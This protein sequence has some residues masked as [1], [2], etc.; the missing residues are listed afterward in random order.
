[1][2]NPSQPRYGI[3]AV[4]VISVKRLLPVELRG[5]AA[6]LGRPKS[7]RPCRPDEVA[8]KVAPPQLSRPGSVRA[9]AGLGA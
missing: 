8:A 1:M 6:A 7:A 2:I 3:D 9:M 4:L 5:I